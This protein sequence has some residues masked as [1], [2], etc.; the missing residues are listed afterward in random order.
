MLSLSVHCISG[1]GGGGGVVRG[2]VACSLFQFFLFILFS[3]RL[4]RARF[5]LI[6]LF[7]HR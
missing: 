3:I 5:R 4:S 7:L 1:K 6:S 2:L